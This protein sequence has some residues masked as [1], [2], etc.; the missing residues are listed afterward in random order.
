[1]TTRREDRH[2]LCS[3][4]DHL[5]IG[6]L[7]SIGGD[8]TMFA[9]SQVAKQAQGRIRVCHVPKTIDNDLPLPGEIPTFGFETARQLGSELVQ[10]LMEDSRT[11]GRWYFVVVMGRS[12][13][14]LALGIGK[15][16]GATLTLIPEEFAGPI[17]MSTVCDVLEGSIL[18]RQALWNRADGVAVIAEGLLEHMAPEEL[19]GIEGV[20]I[21]HDN[22]GHLRLAEVDLA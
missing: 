11:T 22:Y 5:G 4:L 13:G 3:T 6:Y 12:A 16:T 10:N 7:A 8:D 21:V 9:A 19:S 14:H 18:K 2:A 1:T 15:A 17:R 20:R